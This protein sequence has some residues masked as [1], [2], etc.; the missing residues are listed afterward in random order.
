M[1]KTEFAFYQVPK[2]YEKGTDNIWTDLHI[3]SQLLQAHLDPEFDGAS[4]KKPFIDASASWIEQQ[5]PQSK[6][7]KVID[8]G[9]GPGLY[10]ERLAKKGY[11]VTGIDFSARSIKTAMA[12][13]VKQDLSITYVQGDYLAWQ[14]RDTYDLAL[15][16]YCDYGALSEDERK[17]LLENI[18]AA[19]NS[20][21]RLLM[22]NF[23]VTQMADF[24]EETSWTVY[25]KDS[26]WSEGEHVVLN[27]AKKYEKNTVLDQAIILK[28]DS[29]KSYNIWKY[30][31]TKETLSR[32]LEAAGFTVQSVYQDVVG[33]TYDVLGETIA[34]IAEKP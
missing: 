4:R 26:F 28:E 13:A 19:L 34:V 24:T 11:E 9:C 2:I 14:P 10:T 8:Y 18:Y 6:F 5:L 27:R 25:E 15:L 7:A 23:T 32:E 1:S 29:Q 12:S 22:D 3:S 21:G 31:S 17:I 30:F 33:Q 20:G 16:I